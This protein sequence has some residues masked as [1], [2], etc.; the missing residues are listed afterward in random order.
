LRNELLMKN[1]DEQFTYWCVSVY[2][3]VKGQFL[4]AYSSYLPS[5]YGGVDPKL[6]IVEDMTTLAVILQISLVLILVI[7]ILLITLCVLHRYSKRVQQRGE[8]IITLRN[9]FR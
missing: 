2:G 3:S 5:L 8:E 9:S 1:N 6:V 4:A 7:I